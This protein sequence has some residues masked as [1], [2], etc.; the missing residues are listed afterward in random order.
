MATPVSLSNIIASLESAAS[1]ANIDIDKAFQFLAHLTTEFAPLATVL[2]DVVE[3]ST[4]NA[5]LVPITNA[6]STG[7]QAVAASVTASQGDTIGEA[8]TVATAV[9][10]ASGNQNLVSQ[11]TQ[12][13][14]TATGVLAEVKTVLNTAAAAVTGK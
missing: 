8:V 14:H 5:A 4:G 12:A 1:K 13:G 7:A 2:A 6:V 10:K 9:E 11:T 3:T